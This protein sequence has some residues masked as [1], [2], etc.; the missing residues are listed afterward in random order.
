MP[1]TAS[2][3]T[4]TS[5]SLIALLAG[6]A[7]VAACQ[8]DRALAPSHGDLALDRSS[9]D[10]DGG[11]RLKG[12]IAFHSNRDGDFEIFVMRADGSGQTQ[13]THDDVNEFDPTISPDGKHIAFTSFAGHPAAWVM[14][15]D[16]SGMRSLGDWLAIPIWSPDSRRLAML[17]LRDGHVGI[18]VMNADDPASLRL[19]MIDDALVVASSWSPDGKRIAFIT[20]RDGHDEEIW[21][22]DV[23]TGQQA[24]LTDN[25][26]NDE[27]DHAGWS[28]DGKQFLF[29]RFRYPPIDGPTYDPGGDLDIWVMNADGTNA[30]QLTDSPGNDDDPY[31]SPDGRHFAFQSE[32]DGDEDVYVA[33]ADG[34]DVRQLT[35]NDG[36]FDAVPTWA[37]KK[38]VHD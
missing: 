32:R 9:G 34:G 10:D 18:Y 22:L 38:V 30:R 13:L 31:W 35:F 14:N 29:S 4:H 17:G 27:G 19:L 11:D 21:T 8:G 3:R 33:D 26:I 7:L 5:R 24:Q 1:S 15:S 12:T 23:A 28:P 37:K 16:G 25:D 36:I 2:S 20:W 6:V